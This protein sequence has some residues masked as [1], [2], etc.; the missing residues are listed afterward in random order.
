VE[1]YHSSSAVAAEFDEEDQA[2]DLDFH[3][4]EQPKT[5][6]GAGTSAGIKEMKCHPCLLLK[7][8]WSIGL[9]DLP[10]IKEILMICV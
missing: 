8:T 10:R 5:N 6:L 9:M 1:S 4:E 2:A 3:Q 7:D